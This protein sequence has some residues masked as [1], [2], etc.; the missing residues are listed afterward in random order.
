M[1]VH[2][3]YALCK[4]PPIFITTMMANTGRSQKD[5]DVILGSRL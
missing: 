5:L 4:V 3:I 1:Q 2:L